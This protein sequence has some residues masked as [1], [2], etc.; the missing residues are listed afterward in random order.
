MLVKAKFHYADF[1]VTSPRGSFGEVGVMEFGLKRAH[2]FKHRPQ[3][4]KTN[5]LRVDMYAAVRLVMRI[6]DSLHTR[7]SAVSGRPARRARSASR[8]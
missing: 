4:C 3:Q 2:A 8:T 5:T 7:R 6:V 1:P